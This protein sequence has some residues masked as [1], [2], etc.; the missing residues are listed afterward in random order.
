MR[1]VI[2]TLLG[3]LAISAGTPA[4]PSCCCNVPTTDIA[5]TGLVRCEYTSDGPHWLG[6]SGSTG[7]AQTELGLTPNLEFGVDRTTPYNTS[8][9]TMN[10]KYL[11]RKES[12]KQPALAVGILDVSNSTRTSCYLIGTKS[13]GNLRLHAGYIE[14]EYAKGPMVGCDLKAGE[15]TCLMADWMEGAGDY[16]A[17]GVSRDIMKRLSMTLIY[18]FP[19]HTDVERSTSLTVTYSMPTSLKW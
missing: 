9:D 6:R 12:P 14:A 8:Q 5:E 16:L 10:A 15:K 7:H 17:I 11:L 1:T 18:G 3:G 4:C 13:F 19:N 2:L